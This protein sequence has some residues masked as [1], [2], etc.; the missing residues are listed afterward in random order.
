M[1]TSNR[2]GAEYWAWRDM[3]K[4][5]LLPTNKYFYNYG[6]RGIS[7]CDSWLESYDNFLQDMG[8]RPSGKYSLD[9]IDNNGNYEPS[10]C[11]WASK[12]QQDN[13][14]RSNVKWMFDGELL[15]IA[16]IAR[17][18]KTSNQRLRYYLLKTGDVQAAIELSR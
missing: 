8:R 6:G 5:C 12:E 18:V 3:K 2:Y 15:T 10:N 1:S 7:V 17:R 16:Q 14:R 13:N 11:R 4:R 9:R